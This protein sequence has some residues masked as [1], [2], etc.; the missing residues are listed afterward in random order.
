[1]SV[2]MWSYIPEVCDGGG[3]P[4]DCDL[5][6]KPKNMEDEDD[7]TDYIKREDAQDIIARK[8]SDYITDEERWIL[9]Y[10]DGEIGDIPSADVVEVVRCKD[11]KHYCIWQMKCDRLHLVPIADNHY[12]SYGERAEE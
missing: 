11:C 3:C 7:M 5:C 8:L 9:E 10:V 2:S 1:M 12:C 4:G 6:D